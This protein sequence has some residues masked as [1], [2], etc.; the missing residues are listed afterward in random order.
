MIFLS[1]TVLAQDNRNPDFMAEYDIFYNTESPLV[2]KGTLIIKGNSQESLFIVESGNSEKNGA[3]LIAEKKI[4]YRV[5]AKTTFFNYF[6]NLNQELLSK[7][8]IVYHTYLIKEKI[9]Q[10][11]WVLGD[12]EKK[13]GAN[14][15]KKATTVFRGRTF[16]AWYSLDYPIKF[17]PWKFNG[18]PGLIFEIYD[19]TDRYRWQLK[20][21]SQNNYL[22]YFE[23]LKNTKGLDTIS[24]KEYA[25]LRYNK[26]FASRIKSKMP[27]DVNV[28]SVRTT[29]PPRNGIEI[30]FEWE[31]DIKKD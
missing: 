24:M 27:R 19:E 29:R 15:L 5:G 21:I 8:Q 20:N 10:M 4:A 31:E 30:L 14:V 11:H 26:D 16:I 25:D 23:I 17:G 2:K 12:E 3:E 18:L 13:V 6:N 9:P 1:C 7:K 28:I 22:D